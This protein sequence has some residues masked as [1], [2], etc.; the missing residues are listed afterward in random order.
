MKIG[1]GTISRDTGI[2]EDMVLGII[3]SPN[4]LLEFVDKYGLDLHSSIDVLGEVF[5]AADALGA[6]A[7]EADSADAVIMSRT[8]NRTDAGSFGQAPGLL[9]LGHGG[10]NGL[11]LDQ[12][13]THVPEHGPPM[14]AIATQGA[15][16]LSVTH[17]F[18]SCYLSDGPSQ[19][20][21]SS[22]VMAGICMGI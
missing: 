12:R 5:A 19:A 4:H 22:S 14:S 15:T 1:P 6:L 17:R 8:A 16:G 3:A 13:R 18:S 9:G 2:S 10:P 21:R 11:V 7:V 20:T